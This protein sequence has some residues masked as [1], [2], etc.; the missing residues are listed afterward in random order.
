MRRLKQGN[1]LNPEFLEDLGRA[2]DL[3]EADQEC[4]TILLKGLGGSFC[5]G[6]DAGYLL[7]RLKN[8][9]SPEIIE[10]AE[11]GRLL[12]GRMAACP[13][14]LACLLDGPALG[15]GAEMA[16]ACH[17]IVATPRGSIGFPETGMGI[18]PS[19]GGVQ[20]KPQIPGRGHGQ[21]SGAHRPGCWTPRRPASF[22]WWNIWSRRVRAWR[23]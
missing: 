9:Q 6:L 23:P 13:K 4:K 20:R 12:L 14:W 17:T 10:F 3:A 16:L 21:L 5:T 18:Y 2:L 1:A 15:A 11:K 19:L 7:E 8:G 22:P